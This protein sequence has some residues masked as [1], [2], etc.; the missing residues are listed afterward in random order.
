M[1]G[2]AFVLLNKSSSKRTGCVG[3]S[4]FSTLRPERE[5][6][7]RNFRCDKLKKDV[8]W[9]GTHA[10]TLLRSL[11]LLWISVSTNF[12]FRWSPSTSVPIL[13]IQFFLVF[14]AN[15]PFTDGSVVW[16]LEKNWNELNYWINWIL[17]NLL[18]ND[19]L[20]WKFCVHPCSIQTLSPR[21]HDSLS[22]FESEVDLPSWTRW[23][24]PCLPLYQSRR[25]SILDWM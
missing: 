24:F 2:V 18:L 22:W 9:R 19:H 23:L 10:S 7:L 14:L 25:S 12:T 13:S 20:H 16:C 3:I 6:E 15:V 1:H 4:T 8:T 5:I 21:R 17:L 11:F